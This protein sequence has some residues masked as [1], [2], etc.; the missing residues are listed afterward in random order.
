[1]DPSAAVHTILIDFAMMLRM[2]GLSCIQ[3]QILKLFSPKRRSQEEHETTFSEATTRE[4]Y[5]SINFI[6]LTY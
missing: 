6:I 1:M 4:F 5:E 3:Q 2:P